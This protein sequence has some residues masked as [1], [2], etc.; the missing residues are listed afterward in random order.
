MNLFTQCYYILFLIMYI[1]EASSIDLN[2]MY[3][4][5]SEQ[6]VELKNFSKTPRDDTIN[7]KN[8]RILTGYRI[9]SEQQT[10]RPHTSLYTSSYQTQS[11]AYRLERL[12][13]YYSYMYTTIPFSKSNSTSYSMPASITYFFTYTMIPSISASI[14]YSYIYTSASA[15][16]TYSYIY[17]MIP[18]TSA[19]ITYSYIY[20]MIPSASASTWNHCVNVGICNT[21]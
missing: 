16:I 20:T 1:T 2:V 5:D 13:S 11:F 10:I 4:K 15:S 3:E 19:S 6:R 8:D 17:T 9:L 14:T 7:A 12:S 18:S 21:S